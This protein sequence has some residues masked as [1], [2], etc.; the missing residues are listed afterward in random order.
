MSE[1]SREELLAVIAAQSR[2][3]EDLTALNTE[4]AERI[5]VQAERIAVQAE[6]I[7]ELERRLGRNSRNSSQPPSA[8][9]PA[10]PVRRSRRGKTARKQG[11]QPGSEGKTLRLVGDPDAVIDHVAAA[12]A[13]CGSELTAAAPAGWGAGRCTTSRR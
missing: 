1:A 5:A 13:G 8:D 12:C 2:A 10:G 7:A 4:Q 3:I 9:G 6:R 11:K